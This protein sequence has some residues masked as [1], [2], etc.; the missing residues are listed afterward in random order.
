MQS[1]VILACLGLLLGSPVLA[2]SN[3]SSETQQPTAN[4]QVQSDT[5]TAKDAQKESAK[6]D[7]DSAQER[8]WHV[9]LGTVS[10][11]AGYVSNPFFFGPFWPYGFYPYSLAYAPFFYDPFFSPFYGPY[12]SGGFGY[13]PD[14]G[15]VKLSANPKTAQVFLDGAYAGTVNH[16]KNIWLDSGAYNLSISAPGREPYQQRIYV[17]S[18][19][20][21]K[22]NAQLSPEKNPKAQTEERP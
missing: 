2:Q 4:A 19:K 16:L 1:R 21:L 14:K 11:G 3:S 20:S 22:I 7:D 13:A 18:G 9:R 10:L 6:K 8:K 17:L 5:K 12:Y 15:E